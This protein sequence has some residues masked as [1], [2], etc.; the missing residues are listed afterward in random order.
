MTVVHIIELHHVQ[1][2]VVTHIVQPV[3]QL[4]HLQRGV[5]ATTVGQTLLQ[6]LA[7]L[8][9][10]TW[11]HDKGQH[12]ALQVA[13]A[14]QAVHGLDKDV[15]TLVAE[16]V[17]ATGRDNKRLV[18][19]VLAQQGISHCQHL[20]SCGL[21]F[22]VKLGRLG[23][24]AVVKA[25]GQHHIDGLVEQLHT[26]VSG[27]VAHRGKAVHMP[28]GL[29]LYRMLRLHVQLFCHLV[30]IIGKEIVVEGFLIAGNRAADARGVGC[31]DGGNLWHL[32][33]DIEGTK[34]THPLIGLIDGLHVGIRLTAYVMI[35]TLDHQSSGIREHRGL[36]IVA[37][38]MKGVHLIVLPQ[39]CIDS[40]LLLKIGGK[41]HQYRDGLSRHDPASNPHLEAFVMGFPAP[42]GQQ[43]RFLAEIGT[44]ILFPEIRTNKNHFIVELLLQS[45]CPR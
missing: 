19:Q 43:R 37:I 29:L 34:T 42:F 3:G 5:I 18:V 44:F 24:E 11:Y 1:H 6:V 16:L 30:A 9:H 25:I 22:L 20:L 32:I 27:D 21:A 13:V 45:L 39:P 23:N 33:V 35:Q 26:L 38:G 8:A 15:N 31:E 12:L 36:V 7:G 4:R 2:I 14:Q 41:V 10:P 28:G 40:V 17:A